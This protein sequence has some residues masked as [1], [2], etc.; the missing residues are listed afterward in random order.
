MRARSNLYLIILNLCKR[1]TSK[2]V[3]GNFVYYITG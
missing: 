2:N 3:D 1:Y